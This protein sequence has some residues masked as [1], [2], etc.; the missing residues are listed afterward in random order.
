MYSQEN[1]VFQFSVVQFLGFYGKGTASMFG[2]T[3]A[4]EFCSFSSILISQD[5]FY[6]FVSYLY[7]SSPILFIS[8]FSYLT[9]KWEENLMCSACHW[10]HSSQ[11][12]KALKITP[13]CTNSA[14]SLSDKFSHCYPLFPELLLNPWFINVCCF[15]L[16][17][18]TVH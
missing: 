10:R 4:S 8:S 3:T 1:A 11:L 18:P 7:L 15:L 9:W 17:T 2:V 16:A 12:C 6:L 13:V 14:A 5:I